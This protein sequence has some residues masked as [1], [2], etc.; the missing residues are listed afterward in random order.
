VR[1]KCQKEKKMRGCGEPWRARASVGLG[2]ILER[3]QNF[4]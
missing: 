1:L 4:M 2:K 3:T